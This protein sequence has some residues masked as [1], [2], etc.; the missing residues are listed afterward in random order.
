MCEK[1]WCNN[2]VKVKRFEENILGII[3]VKEISIK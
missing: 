1:E 2:F 3:K